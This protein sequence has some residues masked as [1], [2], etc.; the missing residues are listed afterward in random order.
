MFF[1]IVMA[2]LPIIQNQPCSIEDLQRLKHAKFPH[3]NKLV[4]QRNQFPKMI[5]NGWYT[6]HSIKENVLLYLKC[7]LYSKSHIGFPLHLGDRTA[8]FKQWIMLGYLLEYLGTDL[9][10]ATYSVSTYAAINKDA[11]TLWQAKVSHV[12]HMPLMT[13][14]DGYKLSYILYLDTN[15]LLKVDGDGILVNEDIVHE[16]N[17][18]IIDLQLN[19]YW[20][21]IDSIQ[22]KLEKLE[23]LEKSTIPRTTAAPRKRKVKLV[24]TS[25][26]NNPSKPYNTRQRS[27]RRFTVDSM[28]SSLTDAQFNEQNAESSDA[29]W[30]SEIPD[31]QSPDLS[32]PGLPDMEPEDPL[33]RIQSHLNSL[34]DEWSD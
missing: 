28:A 5:V 32:I 1:L 25:I 3:F 14:V 13:N 4:Q 33:D 12:I 6:T 19:A 11:A 31:I 34:N 23:K 15:S 30:L 10:M 24:D 26:S 27:K 2:I 29:K 16:D 7:K 20:N 21:A 22:E 17:S 8:F 18:N 9:F